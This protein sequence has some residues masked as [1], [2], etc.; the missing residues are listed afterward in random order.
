MGETLFCVPLLLIMFHSNPPVALSIAGFDG[1]GGAGV[2]ADCRTFERAGVYGVSVL[3]SVVAQ[4]PGSVSGIEA[5]SKGLVQAQLKEISTSFPIVAAKTGM[6]ATA[7][8]VEA[9]ADF[10]RRFPDIKL[11]IDPVLKA[12][13]GEELTSVK[14]I[15]LMKERL[16]GRACL[17]TPNRMEAE[18]IL[19]MEIRSMDSMRVAA[20]K[21]WENFGCN[22]LVKGG[23]FDQ[24]S[25]EICDV[26]VMDGEFE[27][28]RAPRLDVPDLH[29]T[30]CTLSAAITAELAKGRDLGA[31]VIIAQHQ[32]RSWMK[33]YHEWD[34]PR[35]IQ[36]INALKD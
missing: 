21:F 13:A 15:G 23:H 31:S 14:F 33:D 35:K 20:L 9:V 3:T 11:V 17:V 29:G 32:L 30:G 34:S 8:T 27:E 7:E 22:A 10:F 1:S 6:L 2:H 36:A 4:S 16:F 12:S 25:T 19:G 5:V 28:L 24:V 18:T 26:L